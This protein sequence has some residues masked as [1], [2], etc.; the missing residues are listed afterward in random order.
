MEKANRALER[1]EITS[2]QWN[3]MRNALDAGGAT[4]ATNQFVLSRWRQEIVKLPYTGG[5]MLVSEK[6]DILKNQIQMATMGLNPNGT[7]NPAGAT[8]TGTDAASLIRE[9]DAKVKA[10]RKTLDYDR[11]WSL[12]RMANNVKMGLAEELIA[13]QMYGSQPEINATVAFK[14]ALDLYMDQY[15]A[16]ADPIAFFNANKSTYTADN[17]QDPVNREFAD[18]Y[19]AAQG[20]MTIE[21]DRLQFSPEAQERFVTDF[22]AMYRNGQVDAADANEIMSRFYAYYRG[23]GTLPPDQTLMFEADHPLYNQFRQ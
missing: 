16:D 7:I 2:A 23:Q 14:Q 18:L 22:A 4:K 15:G 17:Y 19:P 10:T 5:R 12:I 13:G 9:I 20:Y 3:I 1:D 11:A 8:I 6:G 21:D